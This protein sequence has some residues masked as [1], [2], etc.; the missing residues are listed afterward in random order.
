MDIAAVIW[1]FFDAAVLIVALIVLTRLAG[2]RS[3]SKMSGYDFAIT[4]AVGS[5]LASVIVT[6]STGPVVGTA[7]LVAL[8]AVQAIL[9]K[10][11]VGVDAAA[12]AM[13]NAPLLIMQDGEVLQH[14]L[15]AAKMTRAD[16]M[17]KLR[18]ANVL[19]MKDV[20]A[21]VFEQTG[22]VS[23][24]HGEESIDDEIMQGVRRTL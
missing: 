6:K 8:F 1:P 9:S 11:R 10:L 12:Q 4:V 24:L 16:L 20:R 7:A 5:V 3:F 19:R 2:L 14:N 22:D 17:A 21:V 23:V 18:E 13:D 15:N